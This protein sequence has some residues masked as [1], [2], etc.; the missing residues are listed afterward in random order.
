MKIYYLYIGFVLLILIA[1]FFV[2]TK[3]TKNTLEVN[4]TNPY[5]RLRG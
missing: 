5:Q 4:Y 2:W 3:T 1:M